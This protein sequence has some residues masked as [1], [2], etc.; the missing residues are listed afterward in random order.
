MR[1]K[2]LTALAL[3]LVA[4]APVLPAQDEPAIEAEAE[5]LL[6]QMSAYL[7]AA[8]RFTFHAELIQDEVL[9]WG[10]IVSGEE[11]VEVA[12]R[13]PNGI[14]VDNRGEGTHR[15]FIYDGG[16]FALLDLEAYTYTSTDAPPDIDAMLDM[17]IDRFNII[18]PLSDF[19]YSDPYEALIEGI[20]GGIYVGSRVIDGTR[21]HH[22]AFT[23]ETVD[24]QV[25]IEDGPRPV[26]R[27]LAIRYKNLPGSPR[28]VATLSGW[29]TNATLAD[30][31]FNT[32]PPAEARR[33]E[34]LEAPADGR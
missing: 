22:L 29:D 1:A 25:W 31:L 26:P 6:R 4:Q 3:L 28:F 34:L 8:E 21:V 2:T 15:R 33:I 12:V 9:P 7:A 5:I 27:R 30:H 14:W 20:T 10:Q 13:R 19:V 32:E 11:A 23:Q 16:T 18:V 17:L 24:W